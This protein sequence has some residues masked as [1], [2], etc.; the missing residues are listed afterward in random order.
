MG[1]VGV[2]PFGEYPAGGLER[3]GPHVTAY[4]GHALPLSNSA[5]VRGTERTLVFDANMLR[6]AQELRAVVDA[7]GPPLTELVLSH[8]HDDHV[9]GAMHFAPPARV[10]ARGYT[11]EQ[12]GRLA[13]MDVREIAEWY[14]DDVYDG[15]A[16][17][18]V[19]G[20]RFVLPEAEV[21]AA[22]AIDLGGGVVVH[23]H[24]F[25]GAAHTEG[26]LWAF[27]DPDG[28]AL[29][30]D[31]WFNACEPYLGS[32]S[33]VG[34]KAAV[35]ELRSTGAR[36]YLPGHG[37]A[38]RIERDDPLERFCDWMLGTVAAQLEQ[39]IEGDELKAAARAAF[40]AQANR[41]G[42]VG[43]PFAVPGFFEEGVEAAVADVRRG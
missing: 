18:E 31:L 14:R 27:V 26:D 30:G 23:L 32:G 20:L 17:E 35:A 33:V 21:E 9:F 24:P 3:L 37:V 19:L 11:R 38:G 39:G 13:A 6:F 41:P 2:W 15:D 10:F 5:I 1:G 40:E 42:A 25:G 16:A 12:L 29:C 36:T 22:Q 34:A 8:H 43:F 7:G 28:V 4:Y